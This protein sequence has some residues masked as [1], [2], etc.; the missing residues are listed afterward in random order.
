MV[1]TRS[2]RLLCNRGRTGRRMR[3]I[4]RMD[5]RED[6]LLAAETRHRAGGRHG[7]QDTTE[8]P[9]ETQSSSLSQRMMLLLL[10]LLLLKTGGSA[11]ISAGPQLI[12]RRRFLNTF[13]SGFFALLRSR[14]TAQILNESQQIVGEGFRLTRRRSRRRTARRIGDWTTGPISSGCCVAVLRG[15]TTPFSEIGITTGTWRRC[16]GTFCGFLSLQ[17]MWL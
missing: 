9:A 11:S 14:F 10:L 8:R 15:Q 5:G 17:R 2:A 3:N 12:Q 1:E 6:G 7:R 4:R 16:P 13:S